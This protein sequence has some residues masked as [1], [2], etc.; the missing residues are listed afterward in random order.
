MPSPS[1]SAHKSEQETRILHGFFSTG[2]LDSDPDL[3]R[4]IARE[5]ERQRD[6]IELIASENIVS[7][8]VLSC[9]KT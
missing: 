5:V 7:H 2:L 4:S 1:H 9:H 8:A 3:A 6:E